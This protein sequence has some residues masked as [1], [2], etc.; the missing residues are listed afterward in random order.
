[1]G[2][3]WR[4]NVRPKLADLRYGHHESVTAL[5]NSF[6]IFPSVLPRSKYLSQQEDILIEVSFLNECVRPNLSQKLVL[7]D[8]VSSISNQQEKGLHN[9]WGE[10]DG[11]PV[12]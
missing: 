4:L 1:V 10:M 2:S 3:K 7:L 6:D 9:F 12:S 5:W 8:N 11:L